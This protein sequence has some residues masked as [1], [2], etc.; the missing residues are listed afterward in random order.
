MKLYSSKGAPNP[1]RVTFFLKEKGKLDAVEIIEFNLMKGEHRSAEYKAKNAT[2]RVPSLEL[3][4]GTVLGES[5]AICTYLES[6]FPETNLLGRDGLERAQ[7]EMWDRRVELM[8]MV[9]I[10]G[11][12]RHGHPAATALEPVQCKEWS[13]MSGE[14]TKKAADYFDKVLG[15]TPYVAGDR[16]TNADITLFICMGFAQYMRFKAWEGRENLSR[17]MDEMK[18]RPMAQA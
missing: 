17:W 18:T 10:A 9:P 16:F 5:R 13:D 1:D 4:D 8:L 11:W 2:M 6:V 3:D 12:F 7:I 15:Q 14:A